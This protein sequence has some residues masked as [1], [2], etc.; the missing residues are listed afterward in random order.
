MNLN[1]KKQFVA[2]RVIQEVQV[3]LEKDLLQG[4]SVKDNTRAV[5]QGHEIVEHDL[6]YVNDDVQSYWE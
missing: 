6:D 5:I 1:M 4:G 3:C 2:P